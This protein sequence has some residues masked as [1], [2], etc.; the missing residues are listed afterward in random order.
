MVKKPLELPKDIEMISLNQGKEEW[1]D[2]IY[3]RQALL[4]KEKDEVGKMN[5]DKKIL[6]QSATLNIL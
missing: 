1:V 5:F 2:N 4:R 6:Q 3:A